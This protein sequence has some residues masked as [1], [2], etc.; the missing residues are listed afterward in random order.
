MQSMALHQLIARLAPVERQIVTLWL[1]GL[2]TAEIGEITGI[3]P[4]TVA[5]RLTRIRQ[6]MAEAMRESEGQHG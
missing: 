4:G 1:E 5:V 2:T 6:S 3:R